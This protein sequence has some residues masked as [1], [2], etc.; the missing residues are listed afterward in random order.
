MCIAPLPW[1]TVIG[2]GFVGYEGPNPM[3]GSAASIDTPLG[4]AWSPQTGLL[5]VDRCG[6][7]L[8]A[9]CPFIIAPDSLSGL[10]VYATLSLLRGLITTLMAGM[11]AL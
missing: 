1:Q 6:G 10:L 8:E 3:T 4:L 11:L 7:Y 2:T 5:M 9:G